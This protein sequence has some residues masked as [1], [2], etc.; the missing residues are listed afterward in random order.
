MRVPKAD[1][2]R[3]AIE[4]SIGH[5]IEV[6]GYPM[7]DRRGGFQW[8]TKWDHIGVY[9]AGCNGAAMRGPATYPMGGGQY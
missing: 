5:A 8:G 3:A 7:W 1:P 6:K 4:D 9:N 2:M